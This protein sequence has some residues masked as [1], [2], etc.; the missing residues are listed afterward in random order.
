MKRL[1]TALL[2]LIILAISSCTT[3]KEEE[4]F[5][6]HATFPEMAT[7]EERLD[8]ASR[9][10]PSKRQLQWQELELTAFIHFGIN[11]FTDN[12]WGSGKEDPVLFNPTQLDTDQWVRELKD[13]GFK[14]VILTAKHHDGFCLWQTETT[15]HSVR[16][17]PWEGGKGDVVADLAASCE[18]YD[19]QLGLYLSPW[20][21]NHPTYGEG[22]AYNQVYL[23]QLREL[24]T[25]YGRVDEVWFD[26]ANG[27]GPNG[28][29]QEYDWGSVLSLIRELQ[30]DAVTA[31]MGVDARWVGNERGYG[32]ETEWSATVLPP[33]SLPQAMGTEEKLGISATSDDLGSRELLEKASEIF[34]YPSEVDVSIRPGW[35]YH[36]SQDSQVK[37]LE[38][39]ADIYFSSVGMNSSLL[40]NIPPNREGLLSEPDV[41]RIREFGDFVRAFNENELDV[42]EGGFNY[43]EGKELKSVEIAIDSDKYFNSTLLQENISK[44]QRIEEFKVEALVDGSWT[45]I[46]RG[47]TIGYKRILLLDHPLKAERV[48]ATVLS[49]RAPAD[50]LRLAAHLVPVIVPS[51]TTDNLPTI[52]AKDLEITG[53]NPLTV[54]IEDANNIR[55]FI[56]TPLERDES[57]IPTAFEFSSSKD[58]TK[59]TTLLVGEYGN[60]INNPIP[61]VRF[62]GKDAQINPL[63]RLRGWTKE[64]EE[65]QI[66]ADELEL[67]TN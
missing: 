36:E 58:G 28:K 66:I 61:Q 65:V 42:H 59:W 15:E 43:I 62:L 41:L 35:F 54:K 29:R 13:A 39:L 11:T 25:N 44:G 12:E 45:E 31:I 9:V 8:I 18:K 60:I 1:T 17:S 16:N 38:Q 27:E 20:D 48:R 5:E 19:M 4:Y 22:D 32:R 21:R 6:Q 26:G 56:F 46:T 34:W 51:V 24:L 55:G 64:G 14:M 10:V 23:E 7:L 57:S 37:S 53:E 30:P 52:H 40:L 3:K 2:W 63:L 50:I 49:A 47:T 67:I 33:G